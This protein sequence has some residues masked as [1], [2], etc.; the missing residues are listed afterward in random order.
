MSKHPWLWG[1][2][3]KK[4]KSDPLSH[5]GLGRYEFCFE[6]EAP[7]SGA[8]FCLAAIPYGTW[9]DECEDDDIIL[10]VTADQTSDNWE[11]FAHAEIS[12][13]HKAMI[14][15]AGTF[16]SLV[17]EEGDV[18]DQIPQSSLGRLL[19]QLSRKPAI[20]PE[21][22]AELIKK[23]DIEEAAAWVHHWSR[24]VGGHSAPS[25]IQH[26][27]AKLNEAKAFKSSCVIINELLAALGS[28]R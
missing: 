16:I 20:S 26:N 9:L 25:D 15:A 18:A 23:Y 10:W 19:L 2:A 28:D 3:V 6:S 13:E 17:P 27:I 21:R 7:E 8:S 11:S 5:R 14:L 24:I 4:L 1:Y 22:I 12:D